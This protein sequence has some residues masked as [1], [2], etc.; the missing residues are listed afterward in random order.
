MWSK[1]TA[2]EA[3]RETIYGQSHVAKNSKVFEVH[4]EDTTFKM[5]NMIITTE[6]KAEVATQC[7]FVY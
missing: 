5:S 6:L 2:F 7:Y 3:H 1:A 4:R